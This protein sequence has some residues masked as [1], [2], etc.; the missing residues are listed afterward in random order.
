ME[1]Q[2][3]YERPYEDTYET[4]QSGN[5]EWEAA[6]E[7]FSKQQLNL[8]QKVTGINDT[9]AQFIW[10]TVEE[11]IMKRRKRRSVDK[12]NVLPKFRYEV[13]EVKS[14]SQF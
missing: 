13:T 5:T 10:R 2:S 1:E 8:F 3:D 9:E 4:Y 7:I 12:S 11:G 14:I 6:S